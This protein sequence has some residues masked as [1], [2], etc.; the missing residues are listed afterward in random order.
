MLEFLHTQP[1]CKIL[2]IVTR[3]DKPKGR[4]L[5][6]LPSPVKEKA[7][8]LQFSCPI[9]QPAKASTEE[10][11]EVLKN[12]HPD[13]FLVVSYGEIIKQNLLDIPKYGCI[14]IHPSLLPKYRGAT[15]IH[16]AVM[17]GDKE[18]GI[19][20][21]EMVLAM[22][23]GPMLKKKV[24]AIGENATFAEVERDL[25]HAACQAVME[26]LHDIQKGRV[27]KE[28]QDS[29]HATYTTKLTAE[30]EKIDWQ[31]SAHG[32]HNQIRAFSPTPG[33]WCTVLIGGG[34][35]RLKIKKSLVRED[36]SGQPGQIV[37]RSKNFLLVACG[38]GALQILEVQLE[39]KKTMSIEEFLRG[40]QPGFQIKS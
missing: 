39:G 38:R 34:E 1:E 25:I 13:L 23:A 8:S 19:T 33:A 29:N 40:L 28:E 20:I 16:R 21:I 7:L 2:G 15:P 5:E 9:F 31:K 24:V 35:K 27:V 17:H 10:F 26:T 36:L 12:L 30:E 37:E 11:A 3:P 14:N 6:V 22:D 32:I 18:T 4:S